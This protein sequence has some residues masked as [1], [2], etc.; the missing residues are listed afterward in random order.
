MTLKGL[1]SFLWL[2]SMLSIVQS[3]H[4]SFQ[5]EGT[6]LFSSHMAHLALPLEVANPKTAVTQI[7]KLAT[8][9]ISVKNNA[10]TCVAAPEIVPLAELVADEYLHLEHKLSDVL[11]FFTEH[12]IEPQPLPQSR[13]ERDIGEPEYY[14][15]R[16]L[17]MYAK[18][19]T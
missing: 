13:G 1:I 15:M 3:R 14:G 6:A 19:L 7:H 12:L 17:D 2:P 11:H 5:K 16:L 10:T 4:Y 18:I 9:V 8:H